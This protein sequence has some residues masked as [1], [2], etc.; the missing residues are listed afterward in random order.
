[1]KGRWWDLLS[2]PWAW[3]DPKWRLQQADANGAWGSF[4]WEVPVLT[5]QPAC[6][7]LI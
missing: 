6:L 3:R 1:M 2:G 5:G 4:T 7:G